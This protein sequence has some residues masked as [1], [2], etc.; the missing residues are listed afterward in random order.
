MAITKDITVN[1]GANHVEV[2][3]IEVLTDQSLPY[4]AATNPYIPLNLSTATIQ[5]QVRPSYITST[6]TLTATDL[7]G[8]I[9]KTDPT[10]GTF[11]LRIAPDDLVLVKGNALELHY[12]YDLMITLSAD[13][14]IKVSEG[15]FNVIRQITRI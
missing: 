15:N 2:F 14:V 12:L 7:N 11:E 5:M 3:T 4:N 1:Q 9:V 6:V 8:R 13:N 10:N